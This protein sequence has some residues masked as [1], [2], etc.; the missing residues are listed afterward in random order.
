MNERRTPLG[1]RSL[2]LSIAIHAAAFVFLFWVIPALKDDPVRYEVIR[3]DMVAAAP[4]PEDQLVVESPDDPEPTPEEEAPVP[5]EVPEPEPD[6]I[7]TPAPVAEDPPPTPETPATSEAE[8]P[9]DGDDEVNVR[10]EAQFSRDYPAYY[11]NITNQIKRCFRPP[12]T[13]R[14]P[15]VVSFSVVRDGTTTDFDIAKSSG[16]VP[17]D[18]EALGAIECAGRPGRLGPLPEE[19]FWDFL[20]IMFTISPKDGSMQTAEDTC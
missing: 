16:S 8:D 19:Y 7:E 14:R 5:V 13:A 18:D 4:I 11:E 20:P 9:R 1:M 6:S 10:I 3:I 15:V 17:F 12:V 2:R